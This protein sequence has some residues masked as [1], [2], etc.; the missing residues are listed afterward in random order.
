MIFP[1]PAPKASV[2]CGRGCRI[3]LSRSRIMGILNLTPDSFYDGGRYCDVDSALTR[4]RQMQEQ[5]ADLLD[6]GGEST[7]P[8]SRPVPLDEELSR[9]IPVVEAIRRESAVPISIDTNKSKVAQAALAAGAD[10]IND[11]SALRFDPAMAEVVAGQGGGLILMHSRATPRDMQQHTE[12]ENLIAEV[13]RSLADAAQ[14]AKAAGVKQEQICLDPG[15]GFAKSVQGNLEVLRRLDE[16]LALGYPV[17]LGTSRKSFIAKTLDRDGRE[18]RLHGTLATLALGAA[19]GA[20][21]F[22]VHDVAAARDVVRMA[23]A[24]IGH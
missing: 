7:R 24:I 2:L 6:L 10:F 21:I 14:K 3:D 22:R 16:F 8:G 5:G 15:I 1:R 18:H 19:C 23:D 11:V 9:V 12:Y 20:R 17:L 13:S 4:A